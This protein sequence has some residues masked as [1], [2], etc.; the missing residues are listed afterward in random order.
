MDEILYLMMQFKLLHKMQH[1]FLTEIGLR[2][3]WNTSLPPGV[4]K[5]KTSKTKI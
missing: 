1:L 3:A 4:S 2:S 5:T